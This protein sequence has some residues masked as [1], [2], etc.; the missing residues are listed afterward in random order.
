MDRVFSRILKSALAWIQLDYQCLQH[1]MKLVSEH[2]GT[3]SEPARNRPPE[4]FRN[5]YY[6]INAWEMA[7]AG[8]FV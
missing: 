4:F 8:W 7:T 2:E 5:L 6:T 3:I 1:D